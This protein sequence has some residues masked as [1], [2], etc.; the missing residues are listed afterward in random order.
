MKQ[1]KGLDGAVGVVMALVTIVVI[2]VIGTFIADTT[3]TETDLT[4]SNVS[5]TG[6]LTWSGNSICS[7]MVNI[8]NLAGVK[9]TWRLYR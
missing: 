5:A 3:V 9:V 7:D 4:T 1:N 8:T 6:A 2:G